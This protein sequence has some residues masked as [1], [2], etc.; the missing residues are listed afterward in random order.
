VKPRTVR[1][2]DSR[3]WLRVAQPGWKGPLDTS[4]ARNQG[5]RWNPPGS[6]PVLYLSA[7]VSTAR[8]QI[9]RLLA[10]TP[11]AIDDLDDNAYVLVAAGIPKSQ[12]CVD[13]VSSAGLRAL[14]LP[15][16][17]PVEKKGRLVDHRVCQPIGQKVRDARFNGVWCRSACTNDGRGRELAWFPAS[18][19]SKARALWKQ[20]LPLSAWIYAKD[21]SDLKVEGQTDPQCVDA[22]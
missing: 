21:W 9:E 1:L 18:S 13:A 3:V 10:G 14:G 6:F 8:L 12:T 16:S 2:P 20:P 22:S 4:Y 19:R 7:D 11:V 5:G 15:S 17:Y